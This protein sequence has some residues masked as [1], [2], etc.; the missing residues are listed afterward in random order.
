M[1][2]LLN[3]SIDEFSDDV[4]EESCIGLTKLLDVEFI[5]IEGLDLLVVFLS[6]YLAEFVEEDVL[7]LRDVIRLL[8]DELGDG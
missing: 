2:V 5:S 7:G 1:F 3:G 8:T 4:A 6:D